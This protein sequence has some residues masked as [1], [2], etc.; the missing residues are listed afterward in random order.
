MGEAFIRVLA[1]HVLGSWVARCALGV[2]PK[3][4]GAGA[5]DMPACAR[6]DGIGNYFELS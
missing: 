5:C 6:G 3:S 2:R 1:V 4:A